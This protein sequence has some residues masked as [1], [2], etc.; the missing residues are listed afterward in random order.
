M[1]VLLDPLCCMSLQLVAQ[2][3]P[4]LGRGSLTSV[5]CEL[6]ALVWTTVVHWLPLKAVQNLQLMQN[7]AAR[8][9]M[10]A[11]G[12]KGASLQSQF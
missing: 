9:L 11:D 3:Q 6:V 1:G 10:G 5:A 8:L 7:L 2:L 12:M 4:Y